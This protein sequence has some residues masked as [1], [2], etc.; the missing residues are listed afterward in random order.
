MKRSLLTGL[1]ATAVI[2]IAI[3]AGGPASVAAGGRALQFTNHLDTITPQDVA[4]PG[5]SA[6]D[7]FLVGSHIVSGAHGRT[8]ASCTLITLTGAGI[9]QCEVDFLLEHGTIT[10]RGITDTA[11]TTVHLVVTGATGRY[12]GKHGSGTLTPNPT[13]SSVVLRLH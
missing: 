11:G 4:P 10:T 9:R 3:T 8:G 7:S 12:A 5:P 2:L 1:A 6:G 13:G